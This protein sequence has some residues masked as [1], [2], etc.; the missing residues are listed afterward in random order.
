MVKTERQLCL[1]LLYIS[2]TNGQNLAAEQPL[3]GYAG[4]TFPYHT[5]HAPPPLLQLAG[6]DAGN[7]RHDSHHHLWTNTADTRG[8]GEIALVSP[9]IWLN[10]GLKRKVLVSNFSSAHTVQIYWMNSPVVFVP[11]ISASRQPGLWENVSSEN[12]NIIRC[13]FSFYFQNDLPTGCKQ[14]RLKVFPFL[15]W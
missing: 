2:S 11:L 14:L 3:K 10:S 12:M 9:L 7:L 13:V 1:H 6:Q 15:L 4:Y 8:H 5:N